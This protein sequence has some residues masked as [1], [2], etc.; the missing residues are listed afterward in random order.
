MSNKLLMA[1]VAATLAAPVLAQDAT[2]EVSSS[3]K[4]TV[5]ATVTKV[6]SANR[7]LSLKGPKGDVVDVEVDPVVKRFPEIKVGDLL[8]V[9]YQESLVLRLEKANSSMPLST[10]VEESLAPG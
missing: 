1:L 4:A 8:T 10:S 3:E 7:V 6:D 9:T 5:T 2:K